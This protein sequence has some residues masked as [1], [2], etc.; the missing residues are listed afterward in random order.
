ME[1]SITNDILV[2]AD[3]IESPNQNA[4]PENTDIE[5]LVIHNISLPPGEF[6]SL[7]IR[8]FFCNELDCNAHPFYGEI[9][10]LQV[11][12]HLLIDRQGAITQFVP[13]SNRA[14]HAGESE[15]CGRGN[16]NDYSIGIEM[17]GTDFEPFTES[18][19]LSLTAVTKLLLAAYPAMSADKIVGHSDIAPGRKTDPGPHFDW[20]RYRQSLAS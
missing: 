17:E 6:G 2:G 19:Y 15:F 18:Q 1:L 3:I 14:W 13:F 12:A 16:C 10:G 8:Q 5:L 11:S 9:A 7:A 20:G 4:R